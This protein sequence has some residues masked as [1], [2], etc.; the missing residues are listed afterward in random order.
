MVLMVSAIQSKDI[1]LDHITSYILI[2]F[3]YGVAAFF[4][5]TLYYEGN[6]RT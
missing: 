2:T 1:K 5:A 6:E 3:F 4:G